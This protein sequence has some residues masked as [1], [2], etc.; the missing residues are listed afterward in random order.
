[1]LAGPPT[2][3]LTF[4]SIER[5]DEGVEWGNSLFRNRF[6]HLLWQNCH[7]HVTACV[8]R[9]NPELRMNPWK[10]WWLML[11]KGQSLGYTH[12]ALITLLNFLFGFRGV[13]RLRTWL[14]PIIVY[15]GLILFLCFR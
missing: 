11:V 3:V 6:H 4:S 9:V 10:I 1:M 2:R 14:G 5:W 7:S 12:H 13:A 15:G 8:N